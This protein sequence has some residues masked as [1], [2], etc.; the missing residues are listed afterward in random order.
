[1]K[2]FLVADLHGF[3]EQYKKLFDAVLQYKP[4][5]VFMA[6]DLL[7]S[8]SVYGRAKSENFLKTYF[9]PALRKLKAELK[10]R[11]PHFFVILGNDDPRCEEVYLFQAQD[12]G[13]LSYAHN[14]LIAWRGYQVMG[15]S[16]IP[17]TPFLLKDWERYDVS[18]F[19]DP[20]C[21]HP[22]DGHHTVEPMED[23]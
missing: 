9:L 16:Y 22:M 20:G 12:E 10:S 5:A 21:T 11:Y 19:V 2:C 18:R 23:V 17:P 6:G 8:S 13:L 7:P 1:M 14:Q 15:L 3:T 4:D